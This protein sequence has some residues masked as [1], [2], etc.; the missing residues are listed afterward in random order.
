MMRNLSLLFLFGCNATGSVSL[1]ADTAEAVEPSGEP[2]A[3]PAGEPSSQPSSEP[4]GEPSSQPTS[5]PTSEPTTEPVNNNKTWEGVREIDF[6]VNNYCTETQNE[7]GFEITAEA[8]AEVYFDACPNCTELYQ[9]TFDP[10][11]ICGVT[12][13]FGTETIF[14]LSVENNQAELYYFYQYTNG[15]IFSEKVATATPNNG[16]WEYDF[17]GSYAYG[18]TEYPYT[19]TGSF[20]LIE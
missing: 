10:A 11:Y 19:A 4:S 7:Y 18:R 9:V 12:V 16:S 2:T 17:E 1:K 3:E 8:S 13:Y 6:P 14:G 5:E 20:Q 15:D